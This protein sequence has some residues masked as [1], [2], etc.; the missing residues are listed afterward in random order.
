MHGDIYVSNQHR[1]PE[2]GWISEDFKR[3][4]VKIN[5]TSL[6][7]KQFLDGEMQGF[8]DYRL[9]LATLTNKHPFYDQI[10]ESQ[11]EHPLEQFIFDG[12]RHGRSL[13]NY[14]LELN[15][16]KMHCDL[17]KLNTV[18]EID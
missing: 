7:L 9:F 17:S 3:V 8:S 15:F 6:A 13:I 16:L 14:L 10:S 1:Y 18:L 11:I 4:G 2:P 12:K 5:P